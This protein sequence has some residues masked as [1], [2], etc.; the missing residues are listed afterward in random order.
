MV[1]TIDFLLECGDRFGQ[2]V[3]GKGMCASNSFL[4]IKSGCKIFLCIRR[5]SKFSLKHSS[6][7]KTIRVY[8]R[9]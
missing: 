1:V 7:G 3:G 5:V 2:G 6:F 8:F 9:I 4:G